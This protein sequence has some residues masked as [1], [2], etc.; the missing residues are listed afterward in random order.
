MDLEPIRVDDFEYLAKKKLPRNAFDYY[1]SGA[2]DE[3]TL[4]EN[5]NAFKR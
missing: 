1:S 2:D 4:K 3:Q 5:V